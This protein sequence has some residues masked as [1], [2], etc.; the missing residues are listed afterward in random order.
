MIN[1][2]QLYV[3]EITERLEKVTFYLE[4]RESNRKKLVLFRAADFDPRASQFL[5]LQ[6]VLRRLGVDDEN[7][8]SELFHL[9]DG[10]ERHFKAQDYNPDLIKAVT[11]LKEFKVI[12]SFVNSVKHGTHGKGVLSTRIHSLVVQS[13]KSGTRPAPSDF[14]YDAQPLIN[15]DGELYQLSDLSEKVVSAWIKLFAEQPNNPFKAF[16]SNICRLREKANI[17]STYK[18]K[19][20]PG[21]LKHAKDESDARKNMMSGK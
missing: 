19:I 17:R 20:P 18:A 1:P 3:E 8:L 4:Q 10:V 13:V 14:T 9:R 16:E 6:K 7:T 11:A 15:H 2:K 21:L 12:A 5:D